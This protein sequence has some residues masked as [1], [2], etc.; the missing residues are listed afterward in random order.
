VT[1]H[2][3]ASD[4]TN[5]TNKVDVTSSG[6]AA[7]DFHT[8]APADTFTVPDLRGRSLLGAGQGSALTQRVLGGSGG[9]EEHTLVAA[10][11]PTHSHVVGTAGNVMAAG[12]DGRGLD[13]GGSY[14]SSSTGSGGAHN[15]MQP[16]AA[17]NYLI[18]T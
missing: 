8:L 16:F 12:A 4:A 10:E 6:S 18:K 13:S 5:N 1:L 11:V 3:T 15:N 2:P 7:P 9:E 14:S 17:M